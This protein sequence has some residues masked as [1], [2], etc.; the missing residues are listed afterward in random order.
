MRPPIFV[1]LVLTACLCA[2]SAHGE[3]KAA[4]AARLDRINKVTALDDPAL[5]PWSMKLSFLLDDDVGKLKEQGTI[6]ELW[7]GPSEY[8]ITIASPSYSATTIVNHDGHFRTA[9]A[10]ETPYLLQLLL[11]QMVHP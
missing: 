11:R 8:K 6:E 10:A 3:D 9:G 1:S 5:K 2:A 7:A 4:L